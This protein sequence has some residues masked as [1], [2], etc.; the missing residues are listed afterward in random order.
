MTNP[1]GDP[2]GVNDVLARWEGMEDKFDKTFVSFNRTTLWDDAD[3]RLAQI[4]I[5][6]KELTLLS[7]QKHVELKEEIDCILSDLRRDLAQ[8]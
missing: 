8:V 4:D 5:K 6:M 7:A 1:P 3:E 2:C